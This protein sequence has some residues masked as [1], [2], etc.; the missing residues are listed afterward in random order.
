MH[1]RLTAF[2]ILAAAGIYIANPSAQNPAPAP[3]PL[4]QPLL[5]PN[6]FVRDEAMLRAP[7][8]AAD[9][10][11]ADIDGRRLKQFL[12]EVDA[13]SLKDR[14]RQPVLGP[15]RRDA[16]PRRDAG[17]GRELLQ[18]ARPAERPSHAVR[19]RA[20]VDAEGLGADL[21]GRRASTLALK[22][23]RPATRTPSTPPEGLEWDLVWAGDGTAA[24]SS[25]ATSRARR[26]SS[27]TSRCPGD[28]RHSAQHR[29]RRRARVR[30]RAPRRSA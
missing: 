16:G 10:R 14:E 8:L 13:I 26:S 19:S 24:T 2:L 9:A 28:I 27:R 22:S 29:R 30:A 11:Y 23:A 1:L 6:G 3:N 15:Q 18:E 5:D 4:G 21:H 7:P 20:A 25:A 17:L 12:M